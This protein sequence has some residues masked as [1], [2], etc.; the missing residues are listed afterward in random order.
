MNYYI[1]PRFNFE[2]KIKGTD[3]ED[4]IARFAASADASDLNLYLQV[5]TKEELDEIREEMSDSAAHARFVTAFMKKELINQFNVPEEDAQNIAEEAYDIYCDGF[6]Q[7]EYECIEEAFTEYKKNA[8]KL[9]E[10][11]YAEFKGQVIDV[12]EDFCEENGIT[13]NNPDKEEYDREAGYEPGEN[14][15]I[16]FGDD[17]DA[18]GDEIIDSDGLVGETDEM[19]RNAVSK[20][21]HILGERGNRDGRGL[22]LDEFKA[23]ER[24]IK[25]VFK[26]WEVA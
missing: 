1:I 17:Y 24:Q 16:L 15:A 6:G 14:A 22:K 2:T 18:I 8:A 11:T 20:F 23:L 21:N 12:F 7:T 4:A 3:K 25:D 10:N 9:N 5:V 26:A 13:I 19:I